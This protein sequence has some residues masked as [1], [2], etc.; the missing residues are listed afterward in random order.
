MRLY[1]VTGENSG[2]LHA[3]NLVRELNKLKDNVKFRAFGGDCL[4]NEGVSIALD[5]KS[6]SFMGFF[7]VLKNIRQVKNALEFCKKDIED[8]NPDAII[9]VDYSSF[10]LR[11]AK[12]T[13]SKGIRNFYY[14]PPKIWAWNKRR[15][16]K[17][18]RYVDHVFVIFPFEKEFY[19]SYNIK[20]NYVG[21]PLLDYVNKDRKEL[22]YDFNKPII[23]LLPGSRKQEI[24]RILPVMLS[25]VQDFNDYQ[26]VIACTK[27][28]SRDYYSSFVKDRDVKLV[29]DETYTLLDNSLAALVTSG[30]ATLE[31]ALLNVPQV[32]CY[33]THWITYLLAKMFVKVKYI[34]LVN[35]LLNELVVK[36]LIQSSLNKINLSKELL[37]IIK[38]NDKIKKGYSKLNNMLYKENSSKEAAELIINSI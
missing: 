18:K 38:S 16:R 2:D 34:S 29:F 9:F 22:S 25:V 5:I 6:L 12:F 23:A 1:I 3:A 21:N 10:N 15:I 30:T 27:S 19:N 33:R 36:E 28:F 24:D 26:F 35:I 13:K 32:V 20:V 11:I 4:R 17:I 7:E 8:F 31:T 37:H 14:I